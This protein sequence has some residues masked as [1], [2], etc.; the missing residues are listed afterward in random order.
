MKV[1]H[2][3][4][5]D[6]SH[7]GW[8]IKC[9]ACGEFHLFDTRWTFNGDMEKPTFRASMLVKGGDI[10]PHRADLPDARFL[11]GGNGWSDS[12]VCHSFVTDGKI[13]FLSDCTHHLAGKTVDLEDF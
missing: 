2:R 5:S 7:C 3:V 11:S 8:T 6:G 4:G 12:A 1:H 13:E 9:P 10:P